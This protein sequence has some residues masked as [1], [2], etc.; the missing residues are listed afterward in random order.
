MPGVR[1][2]CGTEKTFCG[3]MGDH[4]YLATTSIRK[5]S[6]VYP[7]TDGLSNFQIGEI[8]AKETIGF[9]E[10]TADFTSTTYVGW[11][12]LRL[13]NHGK[14]LRHHGVLLEMWFSPL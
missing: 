12:N 9:R 2:E 8:R 13:R 5:M 14:G 4:R 10:S 6:G 3:R 1:I 7:M 11:N